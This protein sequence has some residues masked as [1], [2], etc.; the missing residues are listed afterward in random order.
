[1]QHALTSVTHVL[2][3]SASTLTISQFHGPAQLVFG[4]CLP[5]TQLTRKAQTASGHMLF[6]GVDVFG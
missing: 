1:M 5:H 3:D 6:S 2:L 4:T